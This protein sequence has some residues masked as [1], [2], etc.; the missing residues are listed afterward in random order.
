M[1]IQLDPRGI[2]IRTKAG[3]VS[4]APSDSVEKVVAALIEDRQGKAALP[5]DG[6]GTMRLSATAA[7]PIGRDHV[8]GSAMGKWRKVPNDP[9]LRRVLAAAKPKRQAVGMS[10]EELMS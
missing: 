3:W 9:R 5:T 7:D 6:L 4:F 8:E 10:L 2:R 1:E